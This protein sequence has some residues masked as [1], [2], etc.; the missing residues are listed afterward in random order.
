M[1]RAVQTLLIEVS[2][3]PTQLVEADPSRSQYPFL[4]VARGVISLRT[5]GHVHV[6]WL[7]SEPGGSPH[8]EFPV[9]PAVL[10]ILDLEDGSVTGVAVGLL[11]TAANN[12]PL[13]CGDQVPE[14][15]LASSRGRA[16]DEHQI[17][18]GVV[19]DPQLL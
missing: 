9:F 13:G 4:V 7:D 10:E 5:D 11:A 19:D 17:D 1:H 18:R 16:V 3:P 2:P 8:C 6:P 14:L 15:V 12:T